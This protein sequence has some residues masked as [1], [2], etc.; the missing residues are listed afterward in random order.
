MLLDQGLNLIA[1]AL[2]DKFSKGE[3]GTD[4]T[5]PTTGDT[6]LASGLIATQK[7]FETKDSSS[8]LITLIYEL[9]VADANGETIKEFGTFINDGSNEQLVSRFIHP[10]INKTDQI[11]LVYRVE[12]LVERK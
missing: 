3:V 10:S 11:A 9:D 6:D 7:T 1:L 4:N 2:K 5:A 12:Y 8:N